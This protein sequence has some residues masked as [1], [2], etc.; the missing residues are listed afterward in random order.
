MTI[1]AAVIDLD[2]V[3]A[4][5]EARFAKAE[6]AKQAF[7]G[8]M[9]ALDLSISTQRE[10]NDLFWRTAFKPEYVALDE[11]IPGAVEAIKLLYREGMGHHIIFLTSRP[12]SMREATEQWLEQYELNSPFFPLVMKAPGFQYTKTTVW[13]TGMVQTLVFLY[14]AS[15]LLFVDDE[16]D[17]A[18]PVLNWAL[19]DDCP[20]EIKVCSSLALA[21]GKE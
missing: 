4:N 10:A 3:V 18:A 9:E 16:A 13:K 1:K 7:I 12:E 15:E 8:E 19:A 20:C 11:P 14:G 2:G 6:E 17:N 21:V 5:N